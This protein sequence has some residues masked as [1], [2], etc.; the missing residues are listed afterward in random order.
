MFNRTDFGEVCTGS[1]F[2]KREL[3]IIYGVSR[4]T[5]YDWLRGSEPSQLALVERAKVATQA[6]VNAIRAKVLPL[7][8]TLGEDSRKRRIDAIIKTIMENL[9]K[10]VG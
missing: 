2:T 9:K 1:G 8:S 10:Q 6:I 3:G 7:P 4:Q 5:I